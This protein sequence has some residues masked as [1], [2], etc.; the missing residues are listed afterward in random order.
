MT[1]QLRDALGLS[2]L[3]TKVGATISGGKERLVEGIA[4]REAA[5]W[6][7]SETRAAVP[8]R[9]RRPQAPR[10]QRNAQANRNSTTPGNMSVVRALAAGSSS[11]S[12]GH[13]FGNL[14]DGEVKSE[15]G[16]RP[17]SPAR[18]LPLLPAI[19][20]GRREVRSALSGETIAGRE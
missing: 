10:S 4:D 8:A 1:T 15:A 18:P 16:R 17:V 2:S 7:R 11:L 3:Q 20:E 6:A 12:R 9:N 5:G 14:L 13:R 19:L